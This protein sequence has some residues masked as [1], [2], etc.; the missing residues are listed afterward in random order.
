MVKVM[1]ISIKGG[2]VEGQNEW[3]RLAVDLLNLNEWCIVFMVARME[4]VIASEVIIIVVV[5]ALAR[6]YLRLL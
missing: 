1:A 3:R 4:E 6:S 5:M 2:I